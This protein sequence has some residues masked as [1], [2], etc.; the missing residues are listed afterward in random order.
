MN[1]THMKHGF[2]LVELLVVILIIGILASVLLPV[3]PRAKGV[4]RK[5]TCLNNERQL[6]LAVRMYA[7]H[8]PERN[9]PT[10]VLYFA[11]KEMI[12]PQLGRQAGAPT[13][14]L[15]FVCPADDF[16]L[17][18]IIG[19]WFVASGFS[20]IAGIGFHRQQFTHYSSY[21]LNES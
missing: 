5:T 12:Q 6:N 2:T 13:N 10:N 19:N 4:A 3:L 15:L 9:P 16:N 8:N 1:Q 17:D 11:Y 21:T 14:D 20:N 7:D 18:V